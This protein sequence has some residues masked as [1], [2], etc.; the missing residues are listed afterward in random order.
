[1]LSLWDDTFRA[2]ALIKLAP[3]GFGLDIIIY[4]ETAPLKGR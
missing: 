1:M 2:E 3:I 4:S